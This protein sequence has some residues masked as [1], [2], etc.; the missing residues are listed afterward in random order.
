MI[1]LQKLWDRKMA[2]EAEIAHHEK[3]IV[4][5]EKKISDAGKE[6]AQIKDRIAKI[7]LDIHSG[8]KKMYEIE[9]KLKKLHQ[10]RDVI[11]TEKELAALESEIAVAVAEKDEIETRVIEAMESSSK[12]QNKLCELESGLAEQEPKM[13]DDVAYLKGKIDTCTVEL[14]ELLAKFNHE[15]GMLSPEVKSRFE[16]TIKS[17]E[18]KAIASLE[19]NNCGACHT[20]IPVHIVIEASSGEKAMTCTNCG[21]FIYHRE[22]Q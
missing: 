17:K 20:S 22:N 3:S 12:L 21:R 11:K 13:R 10:R 9:E 7:E 15:L 14:G 2:L 1:D 5:W 6:I 8:E 16:K 18:G 4:F 19:G